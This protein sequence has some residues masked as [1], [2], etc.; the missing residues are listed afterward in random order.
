[1]SVTQPST[2]TSVAPYV[3]GF[4][5]SIGLTLIAY[6]SVVRHE[7]PHR[8]VIITIVGLAIAQFLTQM[9]F[10]LHLG[11]EGRPRWKLVMLAFALLV[12]GIVVI[13]TLWIMNNLNSH[14]GMSPSQINSYMNRQDGL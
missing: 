13:G 6:S 5:L 4:V 12:V 2:R 11:R 7:L 1:M 10:F 9:V 3:S 14:M 8:A